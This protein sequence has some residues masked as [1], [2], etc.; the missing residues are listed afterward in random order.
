MGAGY[1]R[2]R[3][4]RFGPGPRF[5]RIR[6]SHPV[7]MSVKTGCRHHCAHAAINVRSLG[8]GGELSINFD[9]RTL[10]ISAAAA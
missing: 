8:V 2:M 3:P 5:A 7:I 6:I 9:I 1:C 4:L 10:S